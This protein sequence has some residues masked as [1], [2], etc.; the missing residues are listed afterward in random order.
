MTKHELAESLRNPMFAER[1]S[2]RE[3]Y[4]YAEE[5]SKGGFTSPMT[6]FTALHV[7]MNSIANEI[8]KLEN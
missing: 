6:L 3:A 4:L 7:M 8:E 2:I 1:E 5:V